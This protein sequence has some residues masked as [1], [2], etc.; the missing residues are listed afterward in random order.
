MNVKR[1][2]IFYFDN[3]PALT[4]LPPEQRGW[5]LT[6]LMVYADRVWREPEVTLEEIMEQ[7]P[8]LSPEA[9][10][11]CGF[12]GSSIRRDTW[13]WL[14]RQQRGGGAAP[15]VRRGKSD[16]PTAEEKAAADR[17]VLEN[18]ERTR[19]LLERF[20]KEQDA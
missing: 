17:R 11:A 10:L 7:F 9:R 19:R 8:R 1:G 14:S 5:L 20:E 12:M 4:A 18:I 6:V 3:Y 15:S 2:F 16:P 13:R